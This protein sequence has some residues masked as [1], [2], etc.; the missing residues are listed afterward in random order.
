M[1]PAQD[2][3]LVDSTQAPNRKT[4]TAST[5][6]PKSRILIVEDEKDYRDVLTEKLQA[7][8]FQIFQAQD[9]QQALDFMKNADVDLILLDML[10]PQMDG[11]T[12]C[13]KLKNELNKNIPILILTN[14]VESAYPDGVQDFVVKSNTTLEEI[15]QK[16]KDNL[17]KTV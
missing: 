3:T 4:P 15:V 14:F 11:V 13:Y 9:G 8:G 7:E 5:Q 10:M 17:P 2:Q 1:D 12:F 16:V 6:A